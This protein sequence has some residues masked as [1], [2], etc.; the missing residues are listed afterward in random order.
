MATFCCGFNRRSAIRPRSRVIG[1]RCSVFRQPLV[2]VISLL[3]QYR[4]QPF[5]LR[6]RI[7]RVEIGCNI[8]F[9]DTPILA[10]A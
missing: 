2:C 5:Y 4:L 1:T 10:S 6:Y 9:Q 3:L 7:K 8:C